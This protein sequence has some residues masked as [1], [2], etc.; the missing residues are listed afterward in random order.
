[1]N[2]IK[3]LSKDIIINLD[4]VTSIGYSD[5]SIYF[6]FGENHREVYLPNKAAFDKVRTVV[7][8]RMDIEEV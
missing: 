4:R 2:T 1:M 5:S 8:R 7:E 3:I 6:Y